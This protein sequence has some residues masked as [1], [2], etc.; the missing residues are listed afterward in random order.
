MHPA[1]TSK[2]LGIRLTIV[3]LPEPVLPIMAMVSPGFAVKQIPDRA[4]ASAPSYLKET[5]SNS[6]L[7]EHSSISIASFLSITDDLELITSSILLAATPAL[8]ISIDITV[9]IINDITIIIEYVRNAVIEPTC[10]FPVLIRCDA[11]HTIATPSKFISIMSSGG[12]KVITLLVNNCVFLRSAL[13][14]SNRLSADCSLPNARI[15]GMPVSIERETLFR[16]ST[17][18]CMMRNFGK[19]MTISIN[20]IATTVATPTAI[21]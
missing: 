13:A 16:A 8:G 2:N 10:I 15:T 18:S 3:L 19:A 21:T 1:V 7:P 6:N 4:G 12:I 17:S 11:T 20:T 5:L 9:N 14:L